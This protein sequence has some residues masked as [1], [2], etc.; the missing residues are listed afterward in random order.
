[1]A[2]DSQKK[3]PAASP[4][5][6]PDNVA[7]A[8]KA[9]TRD[10]TKPKEA[11]QGLKKHE[12]RMRFAEAVQKE[13][14]SKRLNMTKQQLEQLTREAK[15]LALEHRLATVETQ[16]FQSQLDALEQRYK[17]LEQAAAPT[18]KAAEWFR[19]ASENV[20][21]TMHEVFEGSRELFTSIGRFFGKSW[22]S[23]KDVLKS[24]KGFFFGM[25][26][27]D[28]G[29]SIPFFGPQIAQWAEREYFQES[30]LAGVR[31]AVK[32][33]KIPRLSI[34][35]DEGSWNPTDSN[36]LIKRLRLHDPSPTANMQDVAN[37]FARQFI[38][39][40]AKSLKSDQS[41]MQVV[42][43]ASGLEKATFIKPF[44]VAASAPA[45]AISAPP[46][47]PAP[48]PAPSAQNAVPAT[49]PAPTTTSPPSAP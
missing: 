27:G 22:E 16:A 10:V 45:A 30:V 36:A 40:Q 8:L 24:M 23:S 48:A 5:Q 25:L 29:K 31:Q 32:D 35:L 13:L 37:D 2:P 14:E 38:E 7:E 4:E 34:S 33:K 15:F 41:T 43:T 18:S 11:M 49:T 17:A 20:Q 42:I 12:E 39:E 9:L 47:A 1:M 3:S 6:Q 19:S 26:K 21:K 28:L 46:A 44:T